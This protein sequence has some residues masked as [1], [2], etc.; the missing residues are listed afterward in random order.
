VGEPAIIAEGLGKRYRPWIGLKPMS[1]TE[2]LA[3]ARQR[4]LR[5]PG[6]WRRREIWALRDVSFDI[7][8]GEILGVLGR[9]GAGKSTLL[10]V[11]AGIT[12]P[13]EG[14]A[15][16]HGRVTALIGVG[17]GFHDELT[18]RE[19]VLLSGV[20]LG[21]SRAEVAQKFDA[22]VDFAEIDEFIDIPVKRYS[23]GMRAR[24]AFSVAAHIDPD[25]L[26]VDEVLS[27]GDPEFQ[28]KCHQRMTSM[29]AEGLTGMIVTHDR[30]AV[31]RLC[32][33]ALVLEH[34]RVVFFGAA[35]EAVAASMEKQ[36]QRA[37]SA[38]PAAANAD[39]EEPLPQ[40]AA[41]EEP[42][43][44]P[45]PVRLAD[46]RIAST[47]GGDELLPD[48][49]FEV[50]VE[51]EARQSVPGNRLGVQ[52]LVTDEKRRPLALLSSWLDPSNPLH[53]LGEIGRTSL[54]CEVGELPLRAGRY[55]LSVL[56]LSRGEL[57][58]ELRD[59]EF[60]IGDTDLAGK[61]FIPPEDF[62]PLLVS[63]RW[64]LREPAPA[65]SDQGAG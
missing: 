39:G 35:D 3:A 9:N 52:L 31:R 28:E 6:P 11:L 21:M 42:S 18:G 47:D 63:H 29:A 12:E 61:G 24:L 38:E 56:L 60:Q 22:I 43:Q 41:D 40:R 50:H 55:L 57:L 58:D 16:I 51:L 2:H 19:N 36:T 4:L 64:R 26:L 8:R 49:P 46:V 23:T 62:P 32:T 25:I 27:V 7:S 17:T 15:S 45:S 5:R 53:Q 59:L 37:G 33:R 54:I 1:T 65:P 20:F 13:T 10:S 14:F 44:E 34:G 48:Q 30:N